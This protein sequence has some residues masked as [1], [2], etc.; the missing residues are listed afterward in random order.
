MENYPI[1]TKIDPPE[2]LAF[3]LESCLKD[4]IDPLV[5]PFNIHGDYLDVHGQLSKRRRK[6][7]NDKEWTSAPKK[8]MV[9]ESQDED[10]VPLSDR[11]RQMLL[12]DTS[13]TIQQSTKALSETTPGKLHEASNLVVSDFA[14]SERILPIQPPLTSQPISSISQQIYKPIPLPPPIETPIL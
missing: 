1:F 12:R 7:N 3:Y 13:R 2:V 6:R 11:Q 14:I 5:D 9:I 8:N 4:N 10:E